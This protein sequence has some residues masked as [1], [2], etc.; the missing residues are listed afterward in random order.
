MNYKFRILR[1]FETVP[2]V[3]EIMGKLATMIKK[4]V[5]Q[6]LQVCEIYSNGTQTDWRDVPIV[7]FDNDTGKYLDT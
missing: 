5:S 6:T 3:N 1:S 7:D 4:E 2:E